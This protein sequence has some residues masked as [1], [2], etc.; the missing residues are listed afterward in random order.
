MAYATDQMTAHGFRTMASTLLNETGKWDPDAIEPALA[1]GDTDMVRGT[2]HRGSHWDERV[3]MA[4]W[5]SDHLDQLRKGGGV[6]LMSNL[7]SR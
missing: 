5:W 2:K 4:Q 3:A 6:V 1:H 7:I